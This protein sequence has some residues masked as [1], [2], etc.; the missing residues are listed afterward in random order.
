MSVS[1]VVGTNTYITMAQ[2]NVMVAEL[3]VGSAEWS[4][5]DPLQRSRALVEAF[6]MM[7]RQKYRGTRTGGSSQAAQF[8]RDGIESCDGYDE[9]GT[10][11]PSIPRA[12]VLLALAIV[13]DPSIATSDGV[14]TNIKRAQAGSASVEFFG[15]KTSSGKKGTRFPPS[16]QELLACYLAGG[17]I[18]S[19]Q[20]FGTGA[21]QEYEDDNLTGAP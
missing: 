2:A 5:L 6:R 20:A 15:P 12:Q 19:A 11:P 10:T 21:E 14:A 13:A 7:E 18:G 9:S 3:Y 4:A 1:L 8:P 17:T 16:V